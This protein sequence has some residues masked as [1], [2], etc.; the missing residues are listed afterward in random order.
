M[1][2]KHLAA[3]L[4]CYLCGMNNRDD[5]NILKPVRWVQ[6]YDAPIGTMVLASDEEA[7]VGAWWTGQKHFGSTIRQCRVE[8]G[9]TAAIE[10]ARRWLDDYFAGRQLQEMPPIRLEG[11]PFAL[12]VWAELGKIAYGDTVT[13]GEIASRIGA[14][15]GRRE[16]ARAVGGAVGR[17]PIS[18]ILPCHRVIGSD[19]RLT[20]YAGGMEIK[21][22]LLSLEKAKKGI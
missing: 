12:A 14:Q 22:A 3:W 5:E 17:N 19:G 18:V 10:A 4:K 16:S 15:S 7:L 21:T 13:Y 8:H 6:T 9:S 1:I 20:G 2:Y 11:S